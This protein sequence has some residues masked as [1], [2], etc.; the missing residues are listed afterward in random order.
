MRIGVDVMGGDNAPDAILDGAIQSLELLAADDALVLVGDE[1]VI[2][3]WISRA[4]VNDARVEVVATTE[5]IDMAEPPVEAVRT[6]KDSSISV[7]AE[8]G[9][10]KRAAR[11]GMAPLDAVI[12]AGNTGACVSAF[13]M[14]MRRLPHVHRPGIAVTVPTFAGPIVVIDV[15]ANIEPKPHHLA[16][17]GVMGDVYARRIEGIE[18]P[19]VA[20]MN[21]G[22][23]EQKGTAEMKEARDRLRDSSDLNFIGYIEGR[24]V[25]DG[26]AD[27][28]ITDGVV[29]NVMLKLA[30]GLSAGIFKAIARELGRQS[31]DLAKQFQPIVQKLYADHDYHEYGGAPLLGCNGVCLIAHGSSKAVTIRNAVGRARKFVTANVNEAISSRLAEAENMEEVA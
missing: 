28:V 31:P 21:V 10:E 5:V 1:A 15:G 25:F 8:L 24:A 17:Y 4:G 13:Q 11:R 20:L 7:L 23:E 29:G 14:Y 19:R 16:Q 27:V 18:S 2:T 26:G 3:N 22:G 12:S 9:T 6:K 30:E